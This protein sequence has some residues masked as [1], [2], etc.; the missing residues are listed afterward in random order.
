MLRYVARRKQ[1]RGARSSRNLKKHER[2]GK[3]PG[4]EVEQRAANFMLV[5][6]QTKKIGRR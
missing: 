1:T 3:P 5:K 2:K 6:T 4:E